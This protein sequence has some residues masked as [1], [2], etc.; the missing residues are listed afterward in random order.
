MF[1]V[2]NTKYWKTFYVSSKLVAL[3]TFCQSA[4]QCLILQ[5]ASRVQC[6]SY[7]GTSTWLLLP[8]KNRLNTS[9][10]LQTAQEHKELYSLQV[11]IQL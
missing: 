1:I 11:E 10:T 4:V 9:M 5:H 8:Q 3:R 2:Q 7:C 6:Q